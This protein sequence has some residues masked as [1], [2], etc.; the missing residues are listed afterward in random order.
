MKELSRRTFL[1]TSAI[2]AGGLLASNAEA[3]ALEPQSQSDGM[4]EGDNPVVSGHGFRL[5]ARW[6]TGR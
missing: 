4:Y 2:A 5:P 3:M 6:T 1:Q